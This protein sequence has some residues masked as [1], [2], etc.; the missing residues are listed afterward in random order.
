MCLVKFNSSGQYQWNQ[1]WNFGLED[2]VRALIFDPSENIFL[3]GYTYGVDYDICLVKLNSPPK[4]LINSP[5]QND[6]YG[7]IAPNFNLSIVESD[8]HTTWYTLDGGITNITFSGLTATINQTEWDKKGD[9]LV[10]IEFFANDSMSLE[11]SSEVSFY[12]DVT[13]PTSSISFIP[14]SG[15]NIVNKS[16]TF[17]LTADDGQGSGVASIMYK[18]NEGD[19][20][21]YSNPFDLSDYTTSNYNISYYSI[22]KVSNMENINSLLVKIPGPGVIP[23]YNILFLMSLICVISIISYKLRNKILK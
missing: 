10:T 14:H 5:I 2:E 1:T 4:I 3:A 20:I 11:G 17:T 12:K 15:T 8:L 6:F 16:T 9:G 18:I 23:G 21:N 13:A 22:D 19:W 7:T